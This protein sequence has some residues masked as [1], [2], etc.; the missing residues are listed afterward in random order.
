[1]AE[2]PVNLTVFLAV[3]KTVGG[4]IFPIAP[5]IIHGIKFYTAK[6]GAHSIKCTLWHPDNS[7]LQTK[8]VVCA[9]A[10]KYTC[11]F[12]TPYTVTEADLVQIDKTNFVGAGNF[13][14]GVYETGGTGY[15]KSNGAVSF[16]NHSDPFTYGYSMTSRYTFVTQGAVGDAMPDVVL[17]AHIVPVDVV[18]EDIEDVDPA[19]VL[20]SGPVTPNPNYFNEVPMTWSVTDVLGGT[21][22]INSLTLEGISAVTNNV[23]Q[24]G[25]TGTVTANADGGYD[26]SIVADTDIFVALGQFDW[27]ITFTDGAS[28][29]TETGTIVKGDT[30]V[31]VAS[32]FTTS[33]G[34]LGDASTAAGELYYPAA[35]GFDSIYTEMEHPVTKNRIMGWKWDGTAWPDKE[36]TNMP[37]IP[38]IYDPSISG[39]TRTYFQPGI[40]GGEDLE[41]QSF[42][43]VTTSGIQSNLQATVTSWIP[44]IKH[45]NYFLY[46]ERSYLCS[47]DS[48]YQSVSYNTVVSGISTGFLD[49][50]N[51]VRLNH[52]PKIGVP[53]IAR[54]WLWSDSEGRYTVDR[55]IRKKGLFTGIRDSDLIRQSTYDSN[56]KA[57]LF[58]NMDSSNPEFVISTSG[59]WPEAIFNGQFSERVGTYQLGSGELVGYS[60]G[61]WNQEFHTL[62]SPVDRNMDIQVN[63]YLGSSGIFQNWEV[64][65]GI[66]VPL[67]DYQVGVDFDLGILRFPA[68]GTLLSPGWSV[69]AHYYKSAEIEY[70]PQDTC[71]TILC[72]EGDANPIRKYSDRGFVFLTD[73]SNEITRIVLSADLPE[74]TEDMFGPLYIGNNY[75][76]IIAT[77]YD[78]TDNPVEGATVRFEIVSDPEI[79]SFSGSSSTISAVSNQYGQAKTYYNTPGSIDE[80]GEYI[81]SLGAIDN[82]P[83]YDGVSQTTTLEVSDMSIEGTSTDVFLFQVFTDDP[84]SGY[85][86]LTLPLADVDGQLEDY[87]TSFFQSESIYGPTGLKVGTTNPSDGAI[88]WEGSHRMIWSLSRPQ[89]FDGITGGRKV[90]VATESSDALDPHLFESNAI[91][92]F[93][94]IDIVNTG[95]GAYDIVYNTSTYSLTSPGSTFYSYFVVAPGF[96]E[97]QAS[98]YNTRTKE[99]VYSNTIKVKLG[100]S[101]QMNGLWVVDELNSVATSEISSI[102]AAMDESSVIGKNI[103]LGFR[104]RSP[105]V[106][107]ASALGGVTFL[108]VNESKNWD[109]WP[110]LGH[111]C[112]ISSIV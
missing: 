60:D 69:E 98:V 105:N 100:I 82:S 16:L 44:Q 18:W 32:G 29:V 11:T 30:A 12:D 63:S 67:A 46:S 111:K 107:M 76:D 33:I 28:S 45:G 72:L 61:D 53:I 48:H 79:G 87:Y 77:C 101:P 52:R 65:S 37:T 59:G 102:L 22:V 38:S 3:N 84:I 110:F 108:D 47:D 23:V 70:E 49:G 94:P 90:L 86:D 19:P 75:G 15:T 73:E 6:V 85:S 10:G 62:Y 56:R 51:I 68:S 42:Q 64:I 31:V 20:A 89:V 97:I 81:T 9:G 7:I 13:N 103:P 34:S 78:R 50:R 35:T 1:M 99:R 112:N 41:L 95:G 57:I 5:C 54:R 40:G 8:T 43:I 83:S 2:G 14:I 17:L 24:S 58:H 39:I 80:M 66:A 25:F 106:T 96:V 104:L 55:E 71:D 26:I 92:P 74:I 88:D 21:T 4:P 109:V 27:S 93:Q 91:A 36:L